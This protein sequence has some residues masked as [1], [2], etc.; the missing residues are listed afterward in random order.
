M[1]QYYP[2]IR[3]KLFQ[4]LLKRMEWRVRNGKIVLEES[5]RVS[6]AILKQFF[7]AVVW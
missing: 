6:P 4:F 5:N 3:Q 1:Y 2:P 7:R